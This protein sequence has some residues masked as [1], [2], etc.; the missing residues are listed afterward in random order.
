MEIE[1]Q[2][3]RHRLVEAHLLADDLDLLLAGIRPGREEYRRIARQHPHQQEGEDEHAKERRQRGQEAPARPYHRCSK[4]SHLTY[5]LFA[6]E[7][8]IIDLAVELVGVAFDRGRHHGVLAGLPEW[9][10]RYLAE[11]DGV[12]LDA[13][14]LILGR[15]G[16]ETGFLRNLHQ[17]RIVDR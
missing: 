13:V 7:I 9:Y 17:F 16:F 14:L 2:L 3:F 5:R 12:E 1:H 10:L 6:I 15:I 11:M 8:A 4:G